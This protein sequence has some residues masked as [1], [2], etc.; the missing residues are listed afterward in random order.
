M[1]NKYKKVLKNSREGLVVKR[2]IDF[3]KFK[4]WRQLDIAIYLG[5]TAS[6]YAKKERLEQSFSL[7]HYLLLKDLMAWDDFYV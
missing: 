5:I 4:K 3:R 2:I 7:E 6:G 1:M